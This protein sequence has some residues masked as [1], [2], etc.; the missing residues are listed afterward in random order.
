MNNDI[1]H[2][3]NPIRQPPFTV[4]PEPKQAYAAFTPSHNC[5]FKMETCHVL[6]GADHVLRLRFV[7]FYANNIN[8]KINLQQLSG[9]E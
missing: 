7:R 1:V 8:A 3:P 4:P 9:T 6:P 5:N 2:R